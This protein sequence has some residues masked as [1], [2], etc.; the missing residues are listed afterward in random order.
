MLNH[1]DADRNRIGIL[2]CTNDDT[3]MKFLNKV[4]TDCERVDVIDDYQSEWKQVTAVQ[5]KGFQYTL[6]SHIARLVLGPVFQKYDDMDERKI[7]IDKNGHFVR[8]K[9]KKNSC[10][11]L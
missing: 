8:T 6:G 11:I 4:D 2:A 7:V 3:V 1:R 5:G 10:A 9:R